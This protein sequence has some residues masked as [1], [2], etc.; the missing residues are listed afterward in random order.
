MLHPLKRY[1]TIFLLLLPSFLSAQLADSVIDGRTLLQRLVGTWDLV[2][3][4]FQADPLPEGIDPAAFQL[5]MTCMATSGGYGVSCTYEG[6]KEIF[7]VPIRSQGQELLLWEPSQQIVYKLGGI[8]NSA[9]SLQNPSLERVF[10]TIG[11]GTFT[12]QGSLYLTEYLAA[13]EGPAGK[14]IFAWESPTILKELAFYE[15]TDQLPERK[16]VWRLKQRQ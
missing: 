15:A 13:A 8:I 1:G 2:P 4:S 16:T 11:K 7:G 3:G 6:A 10:V 5:Q 12:E 14:H 9:E